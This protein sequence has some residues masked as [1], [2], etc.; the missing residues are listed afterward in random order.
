MSALGDA[1]LA[2]NPKRWLVFGMASFLVAHIIYVEFFLEIGGLGV[3]ASQPVR[4]L[5]GGAALLL[6]SGLVSWLW[7]DLGPLRP[8]VVAYALAIAAMVGTSFSLDA[9]RWP[10]M[11]GALAFMASDGVLS[12]RLFRHGE[13]PAVVADHAV[14]W[15]YWGGQVGIAGAFLL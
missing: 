6:G 5:G 14:W 2:G 4:L 3:L 15:L 1:F 7:R 11:A 13:Q 9:G 8:A 10:A 12:W